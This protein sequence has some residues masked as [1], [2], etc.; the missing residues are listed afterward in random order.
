MSR[1]RSQDTCPER[2][3]RRALYKAGV[4]F[5]LHDRSL[6]GCPDIVIARARVAVFVDGCFWHGCPRHYVRPRLRRS[7]WDA[8]LIANSR[9]RRVALEQLS[10][11]GWAAFA[12]WECEAQGSLGDW[13]RPILR[14]ISK[15]SRPAF[16]HRQ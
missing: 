1:I 10:S 7:Y 14:A 4:R 8:K 9:R 11:I 6:P 5:R 3:V 12:I 16:R 13:V 15:S 2:A